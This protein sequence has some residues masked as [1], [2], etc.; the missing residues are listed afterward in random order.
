MIYI[1]TS[2]ASLFRDNR[3]T[4][5]DQ[6]ALEV[7]LD[8]LRREETAGSGWI[9]LT[10]WLQQVGNVED[11]VAALKQ[12]SK[13]RQQANEVSQLAEQFGELDLDRTAEHEPMETDS[14][15]TAENERNHIYKVENGLRDPEQSRKRKRSGRD[16]SS[17]RKRSGRDDSSKS[18]RP[19]RDPNEEL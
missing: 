12:I 15:E 18:K 16:D 6:E 5:N 11:L 2:N 1:N 4:V 14:E 7:A 10:N 9:D 8:F 3:A 19:K 13:K 17:I